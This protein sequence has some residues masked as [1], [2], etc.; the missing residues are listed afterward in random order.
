MVGV[1]AEPTLGLTD[2]ETSEFQLLFPVQAQ[3]DEAG[4]SEVKAQLQTEAAPSYQ[5]Q[6]AE[7]SL[8]F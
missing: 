4:L 1:G 5:P 6:A 3:P 7:Y 8:C 2:A